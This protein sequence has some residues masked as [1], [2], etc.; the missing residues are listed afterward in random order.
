MDDHLLIGRDQEI[1]ALF[2]QTFDQTGAALRAYLDLTE[3]L[4]PLRQ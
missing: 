2:R 1:V 3:K 4:K